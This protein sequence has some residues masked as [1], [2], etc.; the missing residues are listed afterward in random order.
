MTQSNGRESMANAWL[1]R[2]YVLPGAIALGVVGVALTW[3][4][5]S[6]FGAHSSL[7]AVATFATSVLFAPLFLVWHAAQP[8]ASPAVT[9][10]LAMVALVAVPLHPLSPRPIT[11]ALTVVGMLAW[12][13]CEVIV[14]GAP[15]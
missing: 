9:L 10:L 3:L 7:S 14:A 12:L 1:R 11:V 4:T 2:R 5:V 8:G 13:A 6:S 15:A